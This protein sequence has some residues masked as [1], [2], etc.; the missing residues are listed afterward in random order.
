[1]QEHTL[2][3]DVSEEDALAEIISWMRTQMG[4]PDRMGIQRGATEVNISAVI[5]AYMDQLRAS[6]GE[7]HVGWNR[8]DLTQNSAPF[9]SAVWDLCR[10]GI[11][12]PSLHHPERHG[13]WIGTR[14]EAT[15]AGLEWLKNSTEYEALPSEHG[16]FALLLQRHAP[17]LGDG[18][19][20]RSLE[21]LACYRAQTYL[22]CCAM[23]GAAAESITLALAIAKEGN[24]AAVLREYRSNTGLTKIE[25]LLMAQQNRHVQE[26]L[27]Q[28]LRLLKYWRDESAHATATQVDEEEAF[29]ALITLLRFAQFA[30]NRWP[31][32][33]GR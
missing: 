24:E 30:D 16:R 25:R 33:T 9:Y 22:A 18:Y 15:E 5:S 17:R 29:L 32:L 20:R 19:L 10:R 7:R 3:E 8:T 13:E 6:S 14:F 2:P 27:P 26:G 23:T 4:R 1:M 31:E 11:L 12:R 21:A 28:F